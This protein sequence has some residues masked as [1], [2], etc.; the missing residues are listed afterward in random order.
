[1]R[2][3]KNIYQAIRTIAAGLRVTLPYNYA[4]TVVVQYPDVPP[5]LQERYRGFHA[6]QIERCIACE[7]CA[8]ACPADCIT[9]GKTAV[10]KMDKTRDIAV[11]GAIT[12]YKINHSTCLLC[13]LCTE[14]CPTD[15]LKM[16]P[17]HDNSCYAR[18]DLITDYVKLAKEGRRTIN[19]LWLLK[20]KLPAWAQ[21]VREHWATLD[22]DRRE[23]MAGAD[24]PEYCRKLGEP[25]GGKEAAK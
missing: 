9:V 24:D 7:A 2:Y 25:A 8:K 1:M 12:E 22:T 19:P 13:G 11:G 17:L 10:R 18:A 23:L 15:C 14:V 5:V 3:F 6:Y 21:K 16:G 4:R 20:D